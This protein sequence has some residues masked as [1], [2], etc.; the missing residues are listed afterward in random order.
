V[1]LDIRGVVRTFYQCLP[2]GILL[3]VVKVLRNFS[4]L[5][6]AARFVIYKVDSS[7]WNVEGTLHNTLLCGI[8]MNI[9]NSL[10]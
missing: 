9:S 10:T 5:L 3:V 4:C 2:S 1:T 7:E 8:L 6:R